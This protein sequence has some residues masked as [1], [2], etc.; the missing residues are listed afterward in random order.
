MDY[1]NKKNQQEDAEGKENIE[2]QE[3]NEFSPEKPLDEIKNVAKEKGEANLSAANEELEANLAHYSGEVGTEEI[4]MAELEAIQSE[5]EG[6]INN[7]GTEFTQNLETVTDEAGEKA[8]VKPVETPNE[9]PKENEASDAE[10]KTEKI[11]S[12]AEQKAKA[13]EITR[14]NF[15]ERGKIISELKKTKD[16]E[17]IK[18]LQDELAEKNE[19]LEQAK[20][21]M[22]EALS[23]EAAEKL[24]A[25]PSSELAIMNE[26]YIPGLEALKAEES[27]SIKDGKK[28]TFLHSMLKT[29]GKYVPKN[30]YARTLAVSTAIGVATAIP[31]IASGGTTVLVHAG[32]KILLAAGGVTI[33][34]K[35]SKFAD[36]GLEKSQEN[37]RNEKLKD[38]FDGSLETMIKLA[39]EELKNKKRD[40]KIRKA[41]KFGLHVILAGGAIGGAEIGLHMGHGL[42]ETFI[43]TTKHAG[44]D[45]SGDYGAHH[46]MHAHEH[47]KHHGKKESHDSAAAA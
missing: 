25:D 5:A 29:V 36:K 26:I 13:L 32:V 4:L 30:E 47:S 7:A 37:K 31:H 22:F 34:E 43:A 41:V 11:E 15:G 8:E 10:N 17:R 44:I 18:Q 14:A 2:S 40:E 23:T 12:T 6:R 1:E 33:G 9:A 24:I 20:M 16:P 19:K 35:L 38:K 39:E 46:A 45:I 3:N 28:Q 42:A 21:L 27:A